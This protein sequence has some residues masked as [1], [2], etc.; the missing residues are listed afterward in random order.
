MQDTP[1]APNIGAGCLR[2][3]HWCTC[4]THIVY[5]SETLLPIV[6]TPHKGPQSLRTPEL[7]TPSDNKRKPPNNGTKFI[8]AFF[9]STPPYPG[10]L[11]SFTPE[12]GQWA[13]IVWVGV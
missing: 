2:A 6:Q 7:Y 1:H 13:L 10:L 8:D 9:V 5:T 3:P 11:F 12:P 4:S